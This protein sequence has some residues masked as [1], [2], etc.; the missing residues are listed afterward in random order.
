MIN[1]FK[2]HVTV[3]TVDGISLCDG[4]QLEES[5]GI[6]FFSSFSMC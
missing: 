6:L 5:E 2:Y 4:G 3:R 1:A